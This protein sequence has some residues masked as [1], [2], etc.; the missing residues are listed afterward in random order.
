MIWAKPLKSALHSKTKSS[1]KLRAQ[2]SLAVG[3]Q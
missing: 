1:A 2:T 3:C